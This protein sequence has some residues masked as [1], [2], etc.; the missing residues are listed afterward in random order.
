MHIRIAT[1]LAFPLLPAH[2]LLL[3]ACRLTWLKIQ[4]TESSL[5]PHSNPPAGPMPPVITTNSGTAGRISV[6]V[7][8]EP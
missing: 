5:L 4:H 2:P 6:R 1:A 3:E 8:V 7:Q